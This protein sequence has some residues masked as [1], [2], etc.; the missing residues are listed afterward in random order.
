VDLHEGDQLIQ[1][2]EPLPEY[3]NDRI[4]KFTSE[5][6]FVS[7]WGTE[8]KGNGM[9]Q[10]PNGVTVA[11]DGSVYVA[12][13]KNRRIQK[14]TPRGMFVSQWGPVGLDDGQFDQPYGVA[15]ASDGA[16]YVSDYGNNRI[17]KFT[18]E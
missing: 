13:T 14:F 9:F 18:V 3:G 17:Q 1:K 2:G 12:D 15:V 6:V 16:V 8:G 11:T 5:G 7:E 4:Q 10:N